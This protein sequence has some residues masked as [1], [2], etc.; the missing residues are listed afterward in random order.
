M[1][2]KKKSNNAV[3][4]RR[5]PIIQLRPLL[6]IVGGLVLVGIVVYAAWQAALGGSR[7]KVSV[8]VKGSPSVK[9][10]KQEV[11][12]GNV[13]LGQTVE[14]SFQVANVGDQQ[15]RF[16]ETPYIEVVEGC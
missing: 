16:A 1:S 11:D 5:R 14:V 4:A 7:P 2:N 6:L 13:Q 3:P 10:D 8:E 12:L 15:L 9:V